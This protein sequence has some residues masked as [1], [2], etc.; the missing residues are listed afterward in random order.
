M[1]G[2]SLVGGAP[3]TGAGGLPAWFPG[4]ATRLAELYY[5]GTTSTFVLSGNT[6]D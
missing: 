6:W 5:S 1:T 3:A 4:W 2:K